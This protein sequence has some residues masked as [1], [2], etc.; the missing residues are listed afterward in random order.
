MKVVSYVVLPNR[1]TAENHSLKRNM[2]VYIAEAQHAKRTLQHSRAAQAE[3]M[4]HDQHDVSSKDPQPSQLSQQ[5]AQQEFA[6]HVQ[7][8][9]SFASWNTPKRSRS[10]EQQAQKCESPTHQGLPEFGNMTDQQY[11]SAEEGCRPEDKSKVMSQHESE[12]AHQGPRYTG[13]AQL[14]GKSTGGMVMD[15]AK[16]SGIAATP[17]LAAVEASFALPSFNGSVHKPSELRSSQPPCSVDGNS[18]QHLQAQ[19]D[20][21]QTDE[22]PRRHVR[23]TLHHRYESN[24]EEHS[25]RALQHLGSC[26][27]PQHSTTCE[28]A[29]T[30]SNSRYRKEASPVAVKFAFARYG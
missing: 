16:R 5:H 4:A 1:L 28:Y 20:D 17:A 26:E 19:T 6:E 8:N 12:S 30:V 7:L 24:Q 25:D 22:Q 15:D 9:Q 3:H 29:V 11:G 21:A 18:A 10:L 23:Q 27:T 14:P 13:S 2:G